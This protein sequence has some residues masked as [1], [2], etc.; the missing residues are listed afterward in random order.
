MALLGALESSSADAW[1]EIRTGFI[2]AFDPL[3]CLG[4]KPS[5][6]LIQNKMAFARPGREHPVAPKV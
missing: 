2:T 1:G 3:L 6:N 5:W 4:K